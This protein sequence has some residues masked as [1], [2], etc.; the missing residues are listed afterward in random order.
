MTD[1]PE[2]EAIMRIQAALDTAQCSNHYCS[3][4]PE[5]CDEHARIDAAGADLDAIAAVVAG[6]IAMTDAPDRDAYVR[7][8]G[9]TIRAVRNMRGEL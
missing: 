1:R 2:A 6:A 4:K 3:G 7:A 9:E 5:D 8:M